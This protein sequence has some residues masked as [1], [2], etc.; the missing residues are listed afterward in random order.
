M[1][2][3]PHTFA[4]LGNIDHDDSDEANCEDGLLV[5]SRTAATTAVAPLT[6]D[7][8]LLFVKARY[9]VASSTSVVDPV[10]S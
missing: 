3:L 4:V 8:T 6:A 5:T 9:T 1:C 2:G 7:R 10:Q